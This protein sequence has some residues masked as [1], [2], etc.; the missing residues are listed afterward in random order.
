M[1]TGKAQVPT[2]EADERARIRRFELALENLHLDPHETARIDN[3]NA[4]ADERDRIRRFELALEKLHRDHHETARIDNLNDYVDSLS[5]FERP[6]REMAERERLD[7]DHTGTASA[8]ERSESG[9]ALERKDSRRS[10][11]SGASDGHLTPG[12]AEQRQERWERERERE[13]EDERERML[14]SYQEHSEHRRTELE[15]R[16]LQTADLALAEMIRAGVTTPISLRLGDSIS[17]DVPSPQAE[18]EPH[19]LLRPFWAGNEAVALIVIFL[20][21]LL[22]LAGMLTGSPLTLALVTSF[23][24]NGTVLTLV[25]VMRSLWRARKSRAREAEQAG[26]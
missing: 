2:A 12:M 21:A 26:P 8:E 6:D 10:L 3:L 14:Q 17:V 1:T 16:R 22:V 18:T 5:V 9:G 11:D 7:A 4:Q 20:N 19:R 25:C 15:L 24:L 23:I 13:R